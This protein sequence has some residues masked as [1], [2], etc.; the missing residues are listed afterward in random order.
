MPG[1][2]RK[3]FKAKVQDSNGKT[4]IH[5]FSCS[6]CKAAGARAVVLA[7]PGGIVL[8]V[9]SGSGGSQR[10]SKRNKHV[11]HNENDRF[12][13]PNPRDHFPRL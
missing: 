11:R 13:I 4:E 9:W 6:G 3:K 10:T 12:D 2:T 7:G 5:N 1:R 8:N